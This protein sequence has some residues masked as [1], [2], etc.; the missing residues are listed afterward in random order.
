MNKK[1]AKFGL[2]LFIFL[3]IAGFITSLYNVRSYST[4]IVYVG[5]AMLFGYAFSFADPSAD[6]FRYA[7]SFSRFDNRLNYDK[8][9]FMYQT[10]ELRD[11]YRLL[12]FYFTS[13]FTKNPKVMYALAGLVYGIFSYLSLRVFVKEKGKTTDIFTF[14]LALVFF[15]YISLANINGFRFWT[16]ALI[17]FYSS[18]H[19]VIKRRYLWILG[20]M[21]TPL[22]HYGFI[23]VSPILIIY[24]FVHPLLYNQK[25][26]NPVLLYVFIVVFI[27][28]WF[29]QTNSIDLGFLGNVEALSGEVSGRISYLNSTDTAV[30]IDSR[31][32]NSFFLSV[33]KYFNYAIKIY[34]FIC[35][36]YLNKFS[37]KLKGNKKQFNSLFAFVLFFYTFAFIATS[38]PSGG[39]FLNIAH[40]FF[41]LLFVKIY[42]VWTGKEIKSL[43]LWS[44]PVFS[45]HIAFTNGMLSLM[46][47]SKT[48]WY[49][50]IFWIIYEG[51]GFYI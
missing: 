45:F 11:L 51:L 34:V 48:F 25:N 33:Q 8:I 18:Y 35:I 27:A 4:A 6:S 23:M 21:V 44:L 42:G 37:K 10:G 1:I 32:Q 49:G 12:L 13:T 17:F 14:V 19:F 43:I 2:P 20:V 46:I 47:L 16:G 41:L 5:F 36:L 30:L 15:T 7:Q 39:R 28:S 22:F 40:L 29:L 26:Y 24:G 9:I 3:P 31:Q 50:N 38:F